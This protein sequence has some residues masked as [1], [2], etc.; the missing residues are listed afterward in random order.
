MTT[1]IKNASG[2]DQDISSIADLWHVAMWL[3]DEAKRRRDGPGDLI[4][5]SLLDTWS[6]QVLQTW[7]QAH[8]MKHYV[9]T[10][11]G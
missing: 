2:V 10:H 7:H 11:E 5:A 8:A 4:A 3:K 6:E 9:D 1:S